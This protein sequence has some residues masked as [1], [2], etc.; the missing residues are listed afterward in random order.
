MPVCFFVVILAYPA[1]QSFG[2]EKTDH[3]TLISIE[4]N[5]E[6]LK[7]VLEKISKNT[8]YRILLSEEWQE[9]PISIKLKNETLRVSISRLL[10]GLNYAITWDENRKMISLFICHPGKCGGSML[11]VSLSGQRTNF[12]QS[13]STIV[14]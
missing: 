3:A 14:E 1:I 11:D 13:S 4:A 9:Q 12:E 8:G 10:K 2:A 7:N 5:N 6:S